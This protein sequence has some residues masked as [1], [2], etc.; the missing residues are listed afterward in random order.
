MIDH[1]GSEAGDNCELFTTYAIGPHDNFAAYPVSSFILCI[2]IS[3]ICRCEI[4]LPLNERPSV[5][6]GG[7]MSSVDTARRG[8]CA[9]NVARLRNVND[10]F[11]LRKGI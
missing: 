5:S 10:G 7:G 9:Q 11:I 8:H 4:H 1:D 3:I 6:K 2:S